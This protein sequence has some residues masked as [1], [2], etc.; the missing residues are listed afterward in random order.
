M[1]YLVSVGG[2]A[3]KGRHAEMSKLAFFLS[4]IIDN[5]KVV[6]THG[7]GPQV[8][9]IESALPETKLGIA[10]A[11]TQAEIGIRLKEGVLASFEHSKDHRELRMDVLITEVFVKDTKHDMKPVKPIGSY[12][13]TREEALR[14]LGNVPLAS[15]GKGYRRVVPS[16]EPLRLARPDTLHALLECND[17][18]IAGGGG[19]VPVMETGRGR[20]MVECVVDKDYT[21]AMIAQEIGSSMMYIFTD[22][23][24]VYEGFGTKKQ[25]L[26]ERMSAKEAKEMAERG[27]LEGGSIKPKVSAAAKFTERTGGISV[28]ANLLK[29]ESALSLSGCTVIYSGN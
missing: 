2:N 7:N 14:E 21:S 6:L 25:K 24:G 13:K 9:A 10:T 8:G 5:G 26:I 28:I 19:G 1:P 22:V 3:L 27:H 23:D 18:V 12:Y 16:P 29:P 20:E 11:M 17:I 4:R 15:Y